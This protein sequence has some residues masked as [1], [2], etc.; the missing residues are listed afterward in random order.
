MFNLSDPQIFLREMTNQFLDQVRHFFEIGVGPVNFEHGELGIVLSRNA[1]VA[2]IPVD[3]E[4]FVESADQVI[5][6][7]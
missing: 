3:L 1:F 5:A 7:E 6:L 2:E 4:N